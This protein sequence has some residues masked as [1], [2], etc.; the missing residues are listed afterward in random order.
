MRQFLF[1]VAAS[2]LESA[3]AV[4]Q[5]A[6]GQIVPFSS[7]L[8]ACASLCGKLS[9]VQGACVPPV[10]ST[11]SSDCFCS[12][13]RLTPFLQGPSGVQS[14]CTAAAGCSTNEYQAIEDWYSNLCKKAEQNLGGG[15]TP[16]TT[17][18]SGSQSTGSSSKS[19]SSTKGSWISTHVGWLVGIIV[20]FGTIIIAWFVGLWW[21]KRWHKKKEERVIAHRKDLAWDHHPLQH[22]SDPIAPIPNVVSPYNG[23]GG[24]E[25]YGPTVTTIPTP[26]WSPKERY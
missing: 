12:D 17:T 11:V 22:M 9:D 14:V 23:V 6:D 21:R 19:S 26:V 5:L 2:L 10:V 20:L 7:K 16:T 8:P 25:K 4:T 15:T 18:A 1:F 13:S 3:T 24:M